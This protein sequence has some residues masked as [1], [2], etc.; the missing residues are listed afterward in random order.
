MHKFLP[1]T[2][3]VL[4]PEQD[5]NKYINKVLT[6]PEL[7]KRFFC[8]LYQSLEQEDS[9]P[10]IHWLIEGV[11]KALYLLTKKA[12]LTE[13]DSNVVEEKGDLW[14]AFLLMLPD[15]LNRSRTF[16]LLLLELA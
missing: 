9:G 8:L 10:F 12:A 1:Q 2:M 11:R 4:F 5:R 3:E 7:N 13:S 16:P 15:S 6:L 14:K